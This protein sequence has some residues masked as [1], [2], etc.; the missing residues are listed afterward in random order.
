MVSSLPSPLLPLASPSSSLIDF[1]YSLSPCFLSLSSNTIFS[2]LNLPL[3]LLCFLFSSSAIIS[4]TC[5]DFLTP[6]HCV[7]Q[8][9]FLFSEILFTVLLMFWSVIFL[10]C[11]SF[12]CCIFSS[13]DS[14]L[15]GYPSSP[16]TSYH[17][18]T[19]TLSFG[20][21]FSL[22]FQLSFSSLL[23]S[24]A[25]LLSYLTPSIPSLLPNLTLFPRFFT[26]MTPFTTPL[27][28]LHPLLFSSVSHPFPL[29]FASFPFTLPLHILIMPRYL[30]LAPPL[31]P[32]NPYL[33]PFSLIHLLVVILPTFYSST[34]SSSPL[35]IASLFPHTLPCFLLP[36]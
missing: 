21:S 32:R 10:V 13:I 15:M 12:S 8:R 5:P 23:S 4:H 35:L 6:T 25:S 9:T 2:L 34:L 14:F 26:L 27:S 18:T 1:F 31:L 16:P 19:L 7:F 33:H 11:I 30:I 17:R 36:S 29:S 24:F 28:L 3:F 20:N 22:L